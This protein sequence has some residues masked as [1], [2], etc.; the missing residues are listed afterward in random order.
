MTVKELIE[1]LQQMRDDVEVRV[2]DDSYG[3]VRLLAEEVE[4]RGYDEGA[5]VA[6]GV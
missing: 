4:F 3:W 1:I 6:L 2:Y 5:Y